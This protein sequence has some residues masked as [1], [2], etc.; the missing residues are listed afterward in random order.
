MSRSIVTRAAGA[1]IAVA[2]MMAS[3]P[4]QAGTIV[5]GNL[6]A[7]GTS[8]L[9]TTNTDIGSQKPSDVNWL[10]QGFNTG[11]SS[12]LSIDSVTL[13]I[14]GG[15]PVAIPLTV[16]IYSS[17][18]GK[19]DAPLFTSSP[20]LVGAGEKYQFAFSGANLSANTDYF[21]VPNGGSWY[22]VGGQAPFTPQQQ[23]ASGYTYTR[24]VE[25]TA[26]TTT[27]AGPW[28]E[29]AVSDRYAVSVEAVPEPSTL[30]LAGVGLA[31]GLAVE[32]NRRRHRRRATAA[33]TSADDSS[34]IALG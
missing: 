5:Y 24:T 32:Q 7:S 1:F 27:P 13:G 17:V 20:T 16:S 2:V 22:L 28:T 12:L 3:L 23:N 19:P 31:G 14:F 8:A 21:V 6:G 29:P 25:S 10:A 15:D 11:T 18:L 9:S 33:K 26:T 30:M 4:S 34:A